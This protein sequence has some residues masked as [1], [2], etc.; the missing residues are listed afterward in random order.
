MT[1]FHPPIAGTAHR[2]S[3]FMDEDSRETCNLGPGH[4]LVVAADLW[5][6]LIAIDHDARHRNALPADAMTHMHSYSQELRSVL[7]L[8]EN[9]LEQG[10]LLPTG[11]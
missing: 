7:L 1:D 5:G 11:D 3:S 4:P 6:K 10:T 8:V 9:H 2:P